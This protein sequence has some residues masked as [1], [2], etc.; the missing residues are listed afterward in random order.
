MSGP[1]VIEAVLVLSQSG[2]YTLERR[3]KSK[4]ELNVFCLGC[5]C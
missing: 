2:Y 4:L 1:R 5:E 3:D